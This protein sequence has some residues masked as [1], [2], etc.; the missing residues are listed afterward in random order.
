M[1]TQQQAFDTRQ[2]DA[3]HVFSFTAFAND[4]DRMHQSQISRHLEFLSQISQMASVIVKIRDFRILA[5][6]AT[7]W[8]KC[9]RK[10]HR[11]DERVVAEFYWV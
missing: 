11:Q 2:K 6:P 7:S 4:G 3:R 10:N 8:L 9:Y 5:N 1:F